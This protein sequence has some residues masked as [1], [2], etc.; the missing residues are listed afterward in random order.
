MNNFPAKSIFWIFLFSA[1]LSVLPSASAKVFRLFNGGAHDAFQNGSLPWDSAY[2]T[3]M[4]VNGRSA[5]VKIYAARFSEPVVE[6]LKRRFEDLGAKVMIARSEQGATGT[7]RW[8]DRSAG[9]IV[10]SP[11]GEPLQQIVVYEPE[12]EK[13][14]SPAKLPIPDFHRATV[15]TTISD[16]KTGTF[17]GTLET[18]ASATETHAFYARA[19]Q[20]EGWKMVAPAMVSDGTISGMAVYQKKKK[21][22]YVQAVDRM[23]GSNTIT[24]LVKGGAL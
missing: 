18:S 12:S 9:F 13:K 6:Q 3:K 19:L 7:A 4:T 2:Q 15:R 10:I 11:A 5:I 17:F 14:G 24:L 22:C 8:P 16:D 1:Y 21:I 23:G 20:A